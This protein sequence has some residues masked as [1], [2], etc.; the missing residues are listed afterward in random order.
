MPIIEVKNL[1][2]LHSED[3]LLEDAGALIKA[4]QKIGNTAP[5]LAKHKCSVYKVISLS[6]E[7]KERLLID[8]NIGK[9]IGSYISQ[10]KSVRIASLRDRLRGIM[11]ELYSPFDESQALFNIPGKKSHI[12]NEALLE[13]SID[14]IY[15]LE[16]SAGANRIINKY[17]FKFVHE[18]LREIYEMADAGKP[19]EPGETARHGFIP[20]VSFFTIRLGSKYDGGRFSML[21][22]ATVNQAIDTAL[23]FLYAIINLNKRR[24]MQ[25]CPVTEDRFDPEK[26][27]DSTTRYQYKKD[28]IIDAA[29]GILLHN[30]GFSHTSIHSIIS[31]K[32]VIT[33]WGRDSKEIIRKVQRHINVSRNLLEEIEI[34]SISRMMVSLQKDYPDGSGFPYLNSNKFK[35]EFLRL[36]QI[37]DFYD[38]MTNPVCCPT[39]YS[40]MDVL[41]YI[42]NNS[43][44]YNHNGSK[45]KPCKRFDIEMLNE[46]K[47]ILAMY[48]AG[49]K[50]YLYD[51]A[52][53]SQ[54]LYV[55]KVHSYLASHIPLISILKDEKKNREYKD[56]QLFFYIPESEVYLKQNGRLVKK[57]LP[58]IAN[59]TIID[60]NLDPGDMEKYE[61]LLYGKKRP[62]AKSFQ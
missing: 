19:R 18:I 5:E 7:E 61:D 34:S 3:I 8:G 29:A 30:L 33:E 57:K 4:G 40:R 39:V 62:V 43:G 24:I 27:T 1:E 52:N 2:R 11:L 13:N 14:A 46:F 22:D 51:K 31:S 32:P 6:R 50:I 36:F 47:T 17:K 48:E 26:H 35:H 56:G 37:I 58:F 55:G 42:E 45:F 44:K 16:I 12:E 20:R 59:L 10:R 25:G 9:N 23:F 49:E 28:L 15:R 38:Q 60:K 41:N 21:G 54:H 53:R